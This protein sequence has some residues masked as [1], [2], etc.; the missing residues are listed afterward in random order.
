MVKV[1]PDQFVSTVRKPDDFDQFWHD[2][3]EKV[4]R[5]PLDPE[6]VNDPLRSSEDLDIHQVSYHSLDRVRIAGWYLL[7]KERRG[8]LPAILQVP[9]YLQDPAIPKELARKGYAVF[10]VAPRGKLRS[11]RQFNP[12]YPGLLTHNITDR[13]T[14]SYRGFMIDAY[15]AVDFLLTREEVDPERIG[16]AGSSQGGGL[17]VTTAALHPAIAAASAGVPYLC[18]YMDAIELTHTYPYQEISDYLRL[19]P[20][21]RQAVEETLAYFDCIHFASKV[22]CP[23]VVNVG[24]NDNVCPPETGCALFNAIGSSDKQLYQYEGAG[25]D[26]GR[27]RHAA[28]VDEFFRKHLKLQEVGA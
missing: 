3:L 12:G 14:Y 7:P 4:S 21:R 22:T 26:G 8:R 19:Y 6:T 18:G 11:N 5:I 10:S 9:G 15:R 17:S 13:N 2:I 25:H 27:H 24:L 16:V 1:A 20:Q 23:I 28:I